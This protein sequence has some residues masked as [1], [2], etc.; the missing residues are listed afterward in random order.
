MNLRSAPPLKHLALAAA[1]A[2]AVALAAPSGL[3]APAAAS[4]SE[5]FFSEYAEGS[6]SNK[7]LELY[8]GTGAPV[9]LTGVYDV[10]IFANGSP[11]ATATIPLAGTVAD[12]DVFVL[13]RSAAAAAVLAQADQTTTNFLW[14]GNDAVALRRAGTIVDVIGQIGSDPGVEWG[15]GDASTA[16][17]TLRRKP[18]VQAG[19][20]NG[21]DAFDPALQWD[22]FP[23]DSFDGLGAHTVST[24]GGTNLPP[25]AAADSALVDEDGGA[26]PID[27][28]ANDSDPDGDGLAITG[29]SDP[30]HGAV[31][32]DG[33][34]AGLSYTP[35]PDWSGPDSFTYTISDGRGG[36][37]AATVAVT[38]E[39]VND[40]PDAE[41]DDAST[42]EDAAVTID[43]LANDTDVDG[44][45][46]AL[47]TVDPPLHG[48]ATAV[49][50]GIEYVPVAD[51]NGT[52]V[53]EYAVS[54]GNGGAETAQVVV[55]VSPVDDPP[56]AVNDAAVVRQG[57]TA[58]LHVLVND[59]A[60]PAD[61]A[62]Q[63]LTLVS[64]GP[65]A[66]GTAEPV[67]GGPDAGRIRYT[68]AAGYRGPDSFAYAVSDGGA[69]A[70]GTVAITVLPVA[71]RTLCALDATIVGTLGDDVLEGTP[72]DDVIRGRRGNDV[73]RGNGGNDIVCAG[74]G[75][76]DVTTL[77]GDD[78][79]TGGSGNDTLTAG[80][81]DDRV[82]GG[83]GRDTIAAGAGNDSV[84]AG[85]GDDT[86]DA[87]DGRNAVA[88]GPGDDHVT[89][90]AGD[91]RVDGGPGTDVCDAG[92]GHNVVLGCP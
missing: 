63:V 36:T 45:A 56:L 2:A 15:T 65:P 79:V 39:P 53:F 11:T 48:A 83:F 87:G 77:G 52:D 49:A 12:G 19:D 72:G 51:F 42:A 37:A 22:G 21:A 61:E 3:L 67:I 62:G 32:I 1:L 75:A 25:V 64:V 43:V 85:P 54:D 50:G 66:H 55:T 60:G 38:V 74:P 46:L 35:D 76:D 59:L 20:Q 10:Q 9:T 4:P 88:A 41:D 8:N 70:T 17:A 14:N 13:A 68:P 78:R 6:A 30:V 71:L 80:A 33:G 18:G 89:A 29:A 27:V 28:L 26:G 86:I 40:D 73:I 84:A 31:T 81:G 44:D 91:D 69:I 57:E 24:G 5:L 7:A 92:G 16:D 23:I 82:R 90:G 34:A 58:V 47:A